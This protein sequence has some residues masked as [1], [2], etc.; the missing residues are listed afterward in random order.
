MSEQPPFPWPSE[1]PYTRF[2]VLS[3]PRTGSNLLQQILNSHPDVMCFRELFN[4]Q[5]HIDYEMPAYDGT[6]AADLALR[7]ADAPALLGKRIFMEQPASVRAVGFKFHYNHVWSYDRILDAL[8]ADTSLRIVHLRR[9]N[10]LRM[11][12]SLRLAQR[13]GEWMVHE[14]PRNQIAWAARRL[15]SLRRSAGP[16]SD[17][18]ARTEAGI[19]LTPQEC[20]QYFWEQ[21][22]TIDKFTK[23]IFVGHSMVELAYEDLVTDRDAA[24]QPVWG[25]LGVR[26][27]SEA[28]VSLRKQNPEPL[29][30][31]ISNYDE[32]ER[33][34]S[35]TPFKVVFREDADV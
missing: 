33:H 28:E 24:M 18:G 4:L 35:D 19:L 29:R 8:A 21:V 31:L 15:R 2:I 3:G 34:F 26:H 27:W 20:E 13:T 11:L 30:T 6:D 5:A 25:F 7:A 9:R 16:T 17:S 1:T 14:P 12:V 10:I 22:L 32:L 23:E